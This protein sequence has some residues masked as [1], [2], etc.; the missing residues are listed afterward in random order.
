MHGTS[1]T[2]ER[3]FVSQ[4]FSLSLVNVTS[5]SDIEVS[6]LATPIG[7]DLPVDR[8]LL[9]NS[10]AG[11]Q[12]EQDILNQAR[13]GTAPCTKAV[14][15]RYWDVERRAWSSR[16]C[17]TVERN[18]TGTT[19][20]ECNHL[21]D[22]IAVRKPTLSAETVDFATLIENVTLHCACTSGLKVVLVKQS[23]G[24]MEKRVDVGISRP[25]GDVSLDQV[26]ANWTAV[27]RSFAEPVWQS[28]LQLPVS[29]GTAVDGIAMSMSA[30]G[31]SERAGAYHASVDVD[32]TASD[33]SVKRVVIPVAA[34]VE[35]T[36]VASSS[37]WGSV[38]RGDACTRA[39]LS[40]RN[41]TL[42][43]GT[44]TSVA[45]TTCDVDSLPV[46]HAL[47]T[48]TPDREPDPR[49]VNA[50][51]IPAG[52][53]PRDGHDGPALGS[54]DADAA[55]PR[56]EQCDGVAA[57]PTVVYTGGGSYEVRVT[58]LRTG[59][60]LLR[61]RVGG[62]AAAGG[63]ALVVTV[64]CPAGLVDTD[65]CGCGCE[66]G[67]EAASSLADGKPCRA[68]RPGTYK[69][70]RG[71]HER[72][73][74]CLPGSVQPSSGALECQACPTGYSQAKPGRTVC[75]ACPLHTNSTPGEDECKHCVNGRYR[76]D[77]EKASPA[78]CKPCP[79]NADCDFNHTT[80][81]TITLKPGFWRLSAASSIVYPCSSLF[82][83]ADKLGSNDTAC[84][85]GSKAG[86]GGAMYCKPGVYGPLCKLCSPGRYF[87]EQSAD[88]EVCPDLGSA[89]AILGDMLFSLVEL[90]RWWLLALVVLLLVQLALAFSLIRHQKSGKVWLTWTIWKRWTEQLLEGVGTVARITLTFLQVFCS[91]FGTYGVPP[92]PLLRTVLQQSS[93]WL[94]FDLGALLPQECIAGW[95]GG[96]L[97]G[98]TSDFGVVLVIR[99]L[100]PLAVFALI[101]FYFLLLR[102]LL[103]RLRHVCLRAP[104]SDN[105]RRTRPACHTALL[106]ALRWSVV[107]G[108]FL[109][110]SVNVAAFKAWKCDSFSSNTR[111]GESVLW[112]TADPYVRCS[113]QA[114]RQPVHE[115]IQLVALICLSCWG[116]L[117]ILLYFAAVFFLATKRA[118]TGGAALTTSKRA[119]TGGATLT[120]FWRRESLLHEPTAA[121]DVLRFLHRDLKP[122]F[123]WWE[124][125]Q[126]VQRLFLTG[127]LLILVKDEDAT[128]RLVYAA[129]ISLIGTALV[130]VLQPYRRPSHNF[131]ALAV[132]LALVCTFLWLLLLRLYHDLAPLLPA[133]E[134]PALYNASNEFGIGADDG[135]SG[136]GGEYI[137]E[138]YVSEYGSGKM[139][140]TEDGGKISS[141][142]DGGSGEADG[143]DGDG[144]TLM[145][146]A[147]PPTWLH[148]VM[149][150][151]S[152]DAIERSM[153]ISCFGLVATV[154]LATQVHKQHKQYRTG[155]LLISDDS[156]KHAS[157][158]ESSPP[159]PSPP[160]FEERGSKLRQ[161][162]PSSSLSSP[163]EWKWLFSSPPPTP[164]PSPPPSPPSPAF[165]KWG[166]WLR[167]LSPSSLLSSPEEWKWLLKLD[168]LT[169]L[170]KAR[171]TR[172]VKSNEVR[173]DDDQLENVLPDFELTHHLFL[174]HCWTY[175]LAMGRTQTQANEIKTLLGGLLPMA[176]IFLDV[177]DLT[178]ISKLEEHIARS[179]VVVIFLAADDV[180]KPG[181]YFH[182]K[183]CLRELRAAQALR[184]PLIIVCEPEI[185]QHID[186]AM[187]GPTI[188][189]TAQ[190]LESHLDV[191]RN[192]A[193]YLH[194]QYNSA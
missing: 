160:A 181:G 133:I 117:V 22:F 122:S 45:F 103:D 64:L 61:M 183:K 75:K 68:C 116:G 171:L 32:L 128:S 175:A 131:L 91:A 5:S 41:I 187:Q 3:S 178:D 135:D 111:T 6:G 158:V 38:A 114:H 66:R 152:A 80:L 93:S 104:V 100:M 58:P 65:G 28:W 166:S 182:S 8:R 134:A 24:A 164:P 69:P 85:G 95:F 81:P 102:P 35:A 84:L 50:S 105:Q 49:R 145:N 147:A 98:V 11:Q 165:E 26:P 125:V 53:R 143:V 136:Y 13:S 7:I 42:E 37:V 167:Q 90:L 150:F 60:L 63:E 21:S 192:C 101:F 27:N 141:A 189:A 191:E 4:T 71:S 39:R 177:D 54:G 154:V 87:H 156:S 14:E 9:S 107:A 82:S 56:A 52:L 92:S 94:S 70:R 126:L 20:C 29:N 168:E 30:Y 186:S 180:R 157:P 132:Q 179:A 25:L 10:C 184:K 57:H 155:I 72:C 74:E 15:C 77:D 194:D 140:S 130:A 78:A 99:A 19:G 118:S 89:F 149:G 161:L 1:S 193:E 121:S 119:S 176:K 12:S 188:E 2:P 33:G 120:T 67:Y 169:A 190:H 163:D 46:A 109:T 172:K 137:S 110:T 123:W 31:L 174:S 83:R 115:R 185:K 162:S 127:L 36:G 144:F 55:D 48:D 173:F 112:L 18:G 44:S 43:L 129:L 108:W 59:R 146:I 51:L 113:T 62:E 96:S 40:T 88:C 86:V 142:E 16:G 106:P 124:V 138:E 23:I 47:P 34:T 73:A 148:I 170:E 159:S 79:A 97:L 76:I 153:L 17:R 139:S 151:S